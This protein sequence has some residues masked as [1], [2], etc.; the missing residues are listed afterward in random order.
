MLYSTIFY[1]ADR[2]CYIYT[3]GTTGLPKA[4]KIKH[5]KSVAEYGPHVHVHACGIS[6]YMHVHAYL[7]WLDLHVVLLTCTY[8][9]PYGVKQHFLVLVQVLHDIPR[10]RDLISS[11][12]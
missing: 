7:F 11:L 12:S 1:S 10:N 9:S 3:S 5:S 8:M 6:M 2:V 4:C